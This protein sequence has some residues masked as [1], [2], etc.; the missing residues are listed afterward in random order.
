[1]NSLVKYYVAQILLT[2]FLIVLSI[3][4]ILLLVTGGSDVKLSLVVL[5][6]YLIFLVVSQLISSKPL[7]EEIRQELMEKKMYCVLQSINIYFSRLITIIAIVTL[8]Y[9]VFVHKQ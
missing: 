7:A 6:F 1:M 4:C 3:Q 9:L 8:L 2:V 5:I